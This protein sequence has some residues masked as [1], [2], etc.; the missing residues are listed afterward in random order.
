MPSCVTMPQIEDQNTQRQA[1]APRTAGPA[2]KDRRSCRGGAPAAAP[3][4]RNATTAPGMHQATSAALRRPLVALRAGTRSSKNQ[5]GQHYGATRSRRRQPSLTRAG[6]HQETERRRPPSA[7]LP[8]QEHQ[9][10]KH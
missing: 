6:H 4:T 9:R 8:I 5:D 10:D 2:R 7:A 1:A 3:D